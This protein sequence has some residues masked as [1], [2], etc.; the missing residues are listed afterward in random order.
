MLDSWKRISD[1]ADLHNS[2][3][4]TKL[5]YCPTKTNKHTITGRVVPR[6]LSQI[7]PES[8]LARFRNSNPAGSEFGENLF[9][10]HKTIHSPD[11]TNVVNNAVSCYKEVVVYNASF[12]MWLFVSFWWNLWTGNKF[13]IFIV[14]VTLIKLWIHHLTGRLHWFYP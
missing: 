1:T 3:Y 2:F 10:G 12:A 6:L 11:E 14:W 5:A 8:N 9:W 13:C 7:Q 4:I